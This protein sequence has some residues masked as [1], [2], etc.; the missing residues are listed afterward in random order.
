MADNRQTIVFVQR[1]ISYFI[2]IIIVK[3]AVDHWSEIRASHWYW[4]IG[5]VFF[6]LYILAH[7]YVFSKKS[8]DQIQLSVPEALYKAGRYAEALKSVE[9]VIQKTPSNAEAYYLKGQC[10]D[11][12]GNTVQAEAAW[13]K[14]IELNPS[15]AGALHDL[16]CEHMNRG[17]FLTAAK[18][19]SMARQS[20][21]ASIE[22]SVFQGNV[23]KLRD[24][25]NLLGK[26]AEKHNNFEK[27]IDYAN[28]IVSVVPRYAIG[29]AWRAKQKVNLAKQ[30]VNL[31]NS[32]EA[33]KNYEEAIKDCKTCQRLDPSYKPV[34]DVLDAA[35][36]GINQLVAKS[37]L[38]PKSRKAKNPDQLW[39]VGEKVFNKYEIRN[40]ISGGMGTVYCGWDLQN[41]MPVALKSVK[42][43]ETEKNNREIISGDTDEDYL[44]WDSQDDSPTALKIVK[45]EEAEREKEVTPEDDFRKEAENWLN[46]E[47]H[48]SIITLYGVERVDYRHL[49][50]IMEYVA[51][52]PDG[53]GGT[54]QDLINKKGKL[55]VENAAQIAISIC[56]AMQ[57]AHDK[58]QL[59]HRDLK[60]ANVFITSSDEVKVGDFGLAIKEGSVLE[61]LQLSPYYA[62]PEQWEWKGKKAT[63]AIDIYAIG[64]MLF[65]MICGRLPFVLSEEDQQKDPEYQVEQLKKLHCNQP[66]PDPASLYEGLDTKLSSLILDCLKKNPEDRLKKFLRDRHP[67]YSKIIKRLLPHADMADKPQR[68][69]EVD[70]LD[71]SGEGVWHRPESYYQQSKNR[72]ELEAVY[73]RGKSKYEIGNYQE[74]LE[75]YR[76]AVQHEPFKS[77]KSEAWCN[78]A[79]VLNAMNRFKEAAD[80]ARKAIQI[81]SNDFHAFLNLSASLMNQGSYTKALEFCEEAIVINKKYWEA[82]V[83]KGNIL[84]QMD[85]I[86]AAKEAYEQAKSLEHDHEF[87]WCGLGRCA[88]C[89]GDFEKAQIM[90][91]RSI[92]INE[93]IAE[94]HA[95]YGRVLMETGR[96]EEG[97]KSA[98]KAIKYEPDNAQ[99]QLNLGS[100][101]GSLGRYKEAFEYIN[102]A[103]ELDP[104]N[105]LACE[106]L[107]VLNKELSHDS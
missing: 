3:L 107:S 72:E 62:A 74:A 64:V 36:E 15:H 51:G 94:A 75:C 43:E 92:A 16:A 47:R 99:W 106:A 2:I 100:M 24:T 105:I 45:P 61:R 63:I 14:A 54:L 32:K 79:Q 9:E 93:R 53:G 87:I 104:K 88:E 97:L 55:P 84:L 46:L 13:K 83:N 49:V 4:Q 85:N 101:L 44:G 1:L 48:S 56:E 7:V 69:I 65:E 60:P 50:L 33:T 26:E 5:G 96:I 17:E 98:R 73:R 34:D 20:G 58:E 11:R 76:E 91:K 90:Y 82:Y 37:Q 70:V 30:K 18:F 31:K 66:P 71:H 89:S 22:L 81:N 86:E 80:A 77:Q 42:L 78:M 10:H 39:Q 23:K 52:S 38:P 57:F 41:D 28:A 102:K 19:M 27:A 25:L 8:P 95:C 35:Y 68:M 12:L 103:V 21:A 67:S 59:V 40:I 6:V 29:F